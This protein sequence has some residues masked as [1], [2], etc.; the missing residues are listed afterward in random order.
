[1][2]FAVHDRCVRP[3]SDPRGQQRDAD[4][5]RRRQTRRPGHCCACAVPVR[6]GTLSA[7][8]SARVSPGRVNAPAL[9]G[10]AAVERGGSALCR[11]ARPPPLRRPVRLPTPSAVAVAGLEGACGAGGSSSTGGWPFEEPSTDFFPFFHPL[12]LWGQ[13]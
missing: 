11:E 7:C 12:Q 3:S 5:R 9:P 1:M 13:P 6:S 10:C 8:G 2:A 4:K